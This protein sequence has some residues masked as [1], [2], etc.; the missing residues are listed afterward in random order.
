MIKKLWFLFFYCDKINLIGVIKMI[1]V[2][3]LG[4]TGITTALYFCERKKF[5]VFGIDIDKDKT[6]L[7]KEKNL[8]LKYIIRF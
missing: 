5:N 8:L 6:K 2:F 3:G 1:T 4:F 7:L